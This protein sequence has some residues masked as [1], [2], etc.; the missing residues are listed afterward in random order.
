MTAHAAASTSSPD[1]ATWTSTLQSPDAALLP[2][3]ESLVARS[4]DLVRNNGLAAGAHQTYIDNVIGA[5][6]LRLASRPMYKLLSQSKEWQGEFSQATEQWFNFWGS[7]NSCDVL[8]EQDFGEMTRSVAGSLFLGGEA[9]GLPYWNPNSGNVFATQILLVDPA[10]IS[11]PHNQSDS[12]KL[13]AGFELDKFG[14]KVAAHVRNTHPGD[15]YG[16]GTIS[17]EPPS[18]ERIPLRTDW[19]RKQFIYLSDKDRI[20]STRGKPVLTSVM[21]EFKMLSHYGT[22]ELQ[23]AIANALISAF[24]TTPLDTESLVELLG[25]ADETK[26]FLAGQPNTNAKLKGGAV[27]PLRPGED[28]KPFVPGRAGASFQQF[29]DTFHH[30][31]AA[32][33]NMPREL[34]LKDFSRT[35]Y[36]SARAALQEAWRYFLAQR[37]RVSKAWCQPVFE[38]VQEEMVDKGMVDAP[39]YYTLRRAYSAAR[40]IG[41]GRGWV[42]VVKEATAAKL[43]VDGNLSTLELEAAEQGQDWEELL[44]QRAIEKARMEDLGLVSPLPAQTVVHVGN[45]PP[46]EPA[47]NGSSTNKKDPSQDKTPQ[48]EEELIDA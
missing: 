10:R 33:V 39:D 44:E 19:G 35:N 24:V 23:T 37:A 12:S 30:T 13:R 16:W 1:L 14:R 11:N 45:E 47:K 31:I 43:R 8:G 5:Q 7:D 38:L 46:E 21:K 28:I 41:A 40:W 25:G 32:G 6:G 36:S 15:R 42:D 3:Q 22:V 34:L 26:K 20:G 48:P 4:I 29:V 18:W 2:E 9:V 27:I 17:G